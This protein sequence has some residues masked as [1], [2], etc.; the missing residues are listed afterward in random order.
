ME[1]WERD[2]AIVILL[3]YP[4]SLPLLFPPLYYHI[5]YSHHCQ[6]FPATSHFGK[7]I[8]FSAVVAVALTLP[9]PIYTKGKEGTEITL[10]SPSS[11]SSLRT[12]GLAIWR[13]G[14]SSRDCH[15]VT[16]HCHCHCSSLFLV[17]FF[18]SRRRSDFEWVAFK[19]YSQTSHSIQQSADW[20]SLTFSVVDWELW[21]WRWVGHGCSL[22]TFTSNMLMFEKYDRIWQMYCTRNSLLK[23]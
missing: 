13:G 18:F 19:A 23:C 22:L 5:P 21:L 1:W 15:Y 20:Y 9:L 7:L 10:L 3:S 2:I 12:M 11:A 6:P 8:I 14:Y 16:F 4:F 17:F